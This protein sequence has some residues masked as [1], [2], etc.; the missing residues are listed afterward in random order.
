MHLLP[1]PGVRSGGCPSQGLQQSRRP[2]APGSPP[3]SELK[4]GPRGAAVSPSGLPGQPRWPRGWRAL[5]TPRLF[6][7]CRVRPEPQRA[8]D[9]RAA[10]ARE[11]SAAGPALC[12]G[13]RQAQKEEGEAWRRRRAR[14]E[15]PGRR[16]GRAEEGGGGRP[17]RGGWGGSQ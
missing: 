12:A 8:G 9:A 6:A 7:A 15:G 17:D 5:G 11:D 16:G 13:L 14:E 2:R 10:E 4:A 1:F 3:L